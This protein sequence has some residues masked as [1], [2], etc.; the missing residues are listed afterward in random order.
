MLLY[1]TEVKEKFDDPVLR[2]GELYLEYP[3]FPLFP[4]HELTLLLLLMWQLQ[5][6]MTIQRNSLLPIYSCTVHCVCVWFHH[7]YKEKPWTMRMRSNWKVPV[8]QVQFGHCSQLFLLY[9]YHY[10]TWC[11]RGISPYLSYTVTDCL[12]TKSL[13][14]WRGTRLWIHKIIICNHYSV[15][16]YNSSVIV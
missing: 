3:L 13:P 4:E 12:I 2:T 7:F 8:W 1:K 11:R 6:N 15:I 16:I 9:L 10:N 14:S 5:K